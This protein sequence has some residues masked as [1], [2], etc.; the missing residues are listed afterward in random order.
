MWNFAW[1]NICEKG[2]KRCKPFH[3]YFHIHVTRGFTQ[4]FTCKTSLNG[5]RI[6]HATCKFTHIFTYTSHGVSHELS[7]VNPQWS[8]MAVEFHMLLHTNCLCCFTHMYSV[9]QL[10]RFTH[11][12]TL[13]VKIV[14]S[15]VNCMHIVVYTFVIVSSNF[16][17]FIFWSFGLY[18]WYFQTNLI[19]IELV[20]SE[21]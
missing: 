4:A 7:H 17:F 11:K 1:W 3:T 13:A 16:R 8:W 18:R 19:Y 21:K 2:V 14:W 15:T 20:K 6:S 5:K 9:N 12:F 10:D